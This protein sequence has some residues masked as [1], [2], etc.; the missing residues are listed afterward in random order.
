MN[1][2]IEENQSLVFKGVYWANKSIDNGGLITFPECSW[3]DKI[4]LEGVELT[5]TDLHQAMVKGVRELITNKKSLRIKEEKQEST[6]FGF[7]N[8][9]N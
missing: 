1:L 7:D 6:G 3:V 9:D 2:K 4:E 5:Y 8:L